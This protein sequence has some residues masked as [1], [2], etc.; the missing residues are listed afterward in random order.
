MNAKQRAANAAVQYVQSGM[1]V[2]LGTGSTADCFLIELAE[3]LRSGALRDIRGVPTSR[4]SEA[5]SRELGI[6]LVSLDECPTPDLT[7]DGADEIDPHLDL[8]KGLGGALLREKIVAQASARLIIIADAGKRVNKLGEK[9]PLPVEITP[10][11]HASQVTFLRSFGCEPTLRLTVGGKPFLTDNGNVIYD[12]R[13]TGI[14]HARGEV[15]TDG[16]QAQF[17]QHGRQMSGSAPDVRCPYVAR[18]AHQFGECGDHGPG[19]RLC[20]QPVGE[21]RRV[22]LDD[23]VVGCPGL[24]LMICH[25]Q[26]P[27]VDPGRPRPVRE[28][29]T[30]PPHRSSPKPEEAGI[31]MLPIG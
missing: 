25:E 26:D 22:E 4:Q 12:C 20:L 8:I 27:T 5:R 14:D 19:E 7:I 30:R 9:S 6:P 29:M 16:V 11:C 10:F 18:R 15:E 24:V 28:S 3:A 1:I 2:G 23:P 13:F 17:V 31:A 21:Q